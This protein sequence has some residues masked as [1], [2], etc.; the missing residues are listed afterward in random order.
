[1]S[2]DSYRLSVGCVTPISVA[3][4]AC[5][6]PTNSRSARASSGDGRDICAIARSRAEPLRLPVLVVNV[7]PFLVDSGHGPDSVLS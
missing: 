3:I 6:S 5:D 1:M 7:D 4:V 2:P